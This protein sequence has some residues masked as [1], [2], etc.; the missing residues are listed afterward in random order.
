[1]KR[2]GAS[3]RSFITGI[4]HENIHLETSSVLIREM[5]L[6]HTKAPEGWVNAPSFGMPPANKFVKISGRRVR[7]GKPRDTNLSPTYGWD[8]EF[9]SEEVRVSW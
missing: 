5:S 1:M 6:E 3:Q 7:Y 8:R 2:S 4:E 9:G